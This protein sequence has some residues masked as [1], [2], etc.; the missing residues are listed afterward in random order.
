[1]PFLLDMAAFA[2]VFDCSGDEGDTDAEFE[3]RNA[4]ER[5][6]ATKTADD[7]P[8]V[9]GDLLADGSV[10]ASM[11]R[12]R[13]S[14]LPAWMAST[15]EDRIPPPTEEGG[16]GMTQSEGDTEGQFKDPVLE[17]QTLSTA[18]ECA[19]ALDVEGERIP[20]HL[21]PLAERIPCNQALDDDRILCSIEQDIA[22]I[23]RPAVETGGVGGG[24]IVVPSTEL[25]DF[26]AEKVEEENQVMARTAADSTAIITD[27]HPRELQEQQILLGEEEE[28]SV[29]GDPS[30]AA[31]SSPSARP[32]DCELIPS[33]PLFAY[34]DSL[35]RYRGSVLDLYTKM[36]P[37]AFCQATEDVNSASVSVDVAVLGDDE[38]DA[39]LGQEAVTDPV[40]TPVTDVLDA[41]KED[42]EKEEMALENVAVVPAAP[43]GGVN[44][45]YHAHFAV[46]DSGGGAELVGPMVDVA[47]LLLLSVQ[48]DREDREARGRG[49]D[50]DRDNRSR[51]NSASS[52]YDSGSNGYY[53]R[54]GGGGGFDDRRSGYGGGYSDGGYRGGREGGGGGWNNNGG[55]YDNRNEGRFYDDRDYRRGG[56]GGGG[57]FNNHQYSNNQQYFNGGGGYRNDRHQQN[58]YGNGYGGGGYNNNYYP[59]GGYDTGGYQDVQN[60]NQNPNQDSF[61]RI[62][63]EGHSDHVNNHHHHFSPHPQDQQGGFEG[64]Q[65]SNG[66]FNDGYDYRQ[67]HHPDGVRGG[68]FDAHHS[69]PS[70]FEHAA[71]ITLYH[72][73]SD[74]SQMD[75]DEEHS[76][77]PANPSEGIDSAVQ[78]VETVASVP[79]RPP[80]PTT[81]YVIPPLPQATYFY[82]PH[83]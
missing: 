44:Y 71:P 16:T 10:A 40:S 61:G 5:I 62:I 49:W 76:D 82:S 67:D 4:R 69:H 56:G 50:G 77:G 48:R 27:E 21:D 70:N 23:P 75:I 74:P 45:A 59:S 34:L 1:M 79:F 18:V 68:G 7:V 33:G 11:G 26:T 42:T 43:A 58:G 47:A 14:T 80:P 9:D 6:Q 39:P 15:D 28:V 2:S 19:S 22:Q 30:P 60:Q 35:A 37:Y 38:K 3:R 57:G 51:H 12:G 63:R 17:G 24:A 8:L 41:E 83:E 64:D 66:H 13:A 81:P 72:A 53:S 65:H 36:G 29:D 78:V 31:V 55:G 52:A 54:G 46:D 32:E 73:V 25:L 20:R